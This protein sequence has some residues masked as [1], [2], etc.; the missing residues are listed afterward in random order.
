MRIVAGK[1]KAINLYTF[2]YENVRPT[3]DKI[4]EAVFSKYQFDIMGS[5]W[6]DLFG[7]T[8]AV[9]L[10]ALS[11]GASKVVVCDD[12]KDSI[13]LINKNYTKCKVKPNLIKTNFIKALKS[14]ADSN[15]KFDFIYLDPPFNTT[16]GEKAIKLIAN[17]NLLNDDGVVIFEHLKGKDIS[18]ANEYMENFENKTYGTIEVS[19]YKL[20]KED[21]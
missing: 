13:A 7:G 4:R 10:E 3:P 5:S 2:D 15:Q 18:S 19:F 20:R 8:G 17:Y 1:F 11:R 12:N 16:L 21:V 9:G 14:L 6:L